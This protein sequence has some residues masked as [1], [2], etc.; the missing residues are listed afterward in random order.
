MHQH[1]SQD[2]SEAKFT[3]R[4]N[5]KPTLQIFLQLFNILKVNKCIFLDYRFNLTNRSAPLHSAFTLD[6]LP[7]RSN[8]LRS[9]P[10]S[11]ASFSFPQLR[12]TSIGSA[13]LW[14]ALLRA[15]L[16]APLRYTPLCYHWNRTCLKCQFCPYRTVT[17][18]TIA[19]TQFCYHTD[20]F[21]P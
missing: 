15:P 14:Y 10:L 12:P 4:P 9:A 3:L 18:H 21:T 19:K 13:S 1:N 5:H 2:C 7:S 20:I 11:Y 6:A 16:G 8:P 17:F